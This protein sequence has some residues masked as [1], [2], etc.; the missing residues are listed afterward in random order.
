MRNGEDDMK[1]AGGQQFPLA[2]GKPAFARL[3]LT[4]GAVPVSAGIIGEG[5]MAAA[6]DA[7]VD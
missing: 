2:C 6:R 4:L 1:V 7:A 3:A 5:L